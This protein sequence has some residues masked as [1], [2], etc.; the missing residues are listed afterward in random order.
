MHGSSSTLVTKLC[1]LLC[2]VVLSLSVTLS[3][4]DSCDGYGGS[5]VPKLNFLGAGTAG[6]EFDE[7][8]GEGLWVVC[9]DG[10]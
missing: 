3:I 8:T 10:I 6:Y 4:D 9:I 7:F 1:E 5:L 2:G